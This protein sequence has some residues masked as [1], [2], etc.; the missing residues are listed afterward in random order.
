MEAYD[1][2]YGLYD[3]ERWTDN[4]LALVSLHPGED[5]LSH[6][7]LALTIRQFRRNKVNVHFGLSLQEFLEQ[8]RH[9]NKLIIDECGRAERDEYMRN[10]TLL[11][12][13]DQG[14]KAKA[15]P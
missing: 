6:G 12:Q 5:I 8:P 13:L 10:Q 11:N 1:T 7:R 15:K 9:I 14:D 3:H 2:T 4:P